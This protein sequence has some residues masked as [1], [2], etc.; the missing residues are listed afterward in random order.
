MIQVTL[1]CPACDVRADFLGPL[2]HVRDLFKAFSRQHDHA[3][4]AA[5][6]EI[7]RLGG[8][9]KASKSYQKL[10]NA[11]KGVLEGPETCTGPPEK[12]DKTPVQAREPGQFLANP[13]KTFPTQTEADWFPSALP[14]LL[15]SSFSA[16]SEE[17]LSEKSGSPGARARG[18]KTKSAKSKKSKCLVHWPDDFDTVQRPAVERWAKTKGYPLWWVTERLEAMRESCLAKGLRF[19]D[20]YL[21]YYKNQAPQPT[22]VTNLG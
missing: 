2:E 16:L 12:P 14:S 9:A 11:S 18:E 8:I 10:A 1:H 21:E 7:G 6:A 17:D 19:V 4:K 15:S 5:R 3:L 20:W 22:R 13:S